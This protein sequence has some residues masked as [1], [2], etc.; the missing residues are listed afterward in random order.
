MRVFSVVGNK[1]TGKTTLT[2]RIIKELCNRGFSVGTVKHSHHSMIMDKEGT[3]TF[4]HK[5]AGA[6]TVVG[7]GSTTFFNVDNQLPLDRI[8]FL[9]KLIDEP[10]FVVIEGFK[11]YP[12]PK[13]STSSNLVDDYTIKNVDAKSLTDE[14][15]KDLV[16]LAEKYAYDIIDTLFVDDCGYTDANKIAKAFIS[17]DLKYNLKSQADVSLSINGVN[18]G[19]NPFVNDF[20]KQTVLGMLKSLKTS[21]YG[22]EDFNKVELLI[23]NKDD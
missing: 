8:L 10:D 19:L 21:E 5:S 3:D 18:I 12:Y 22:V 16:D 15:V 23:N 4:K 6:K 14:D 1:D 20:I 7:I 17:G 11:D 13:I 2:T 9:I